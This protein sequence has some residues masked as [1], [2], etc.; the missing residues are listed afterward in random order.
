MSSK[1]IILIFVIV[2]IVSSQ[3]SNLND[4]FPLKTGLTWIYQYQY[5]YSCYNNFGEGSNSSDSGTVKYSIVDSLSNADSVSWHI[6]TIQD[7]FVRSHSAYPVFDTT[8]SYKDTSSFVLLET[9][10]GNHQLFVEN[11]F[12]YA[13]PIW[14]FMIQYPDSQKIFKY[15]STDLLGRSSIQTTTQGLFGSFPIPISFSFVKDTG[16]VQMFGSAYGICGGHSSFSVNCSL[17][18]KDLTSVSESTNQQNV[19]AQFILYQNYPNPFNPSTLI[20]YYLP[21]SVFVS[22]KVFDVCGREVQ[23]LYNGFQS[24]GSHTLRFNASYLPTGIYFYQLKTGSFM[25]SKPLV[26]IK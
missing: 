10:A 15:Q 17:L 12:Y 26:I 20:S 1:L 6:K 16:V 7:F 4:V 14:K 3:P 23:L 9:L 18:S 21:K 2:G 11:V 25:Q 19:E 22:L 24:R 5:R 13:N 8:Y